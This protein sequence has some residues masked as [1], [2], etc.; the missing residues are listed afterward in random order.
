MNREI[1]KRLLWIKI[2]KH[3]PLIKKIYR[4]SFP[5]PLVEIAVEKGAK[6]AARVL[7]PIS[8]RK[9][10]NDLPDDVLTKVISSVIAIRGT[11]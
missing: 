8:A 3:G 7:M 2:S 4:E 10:L 11:R 5:K 1:G 6:A 9:Q